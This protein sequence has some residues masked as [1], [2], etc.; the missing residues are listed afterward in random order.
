[1]LPALMSINRKEFAELCVAKLENMI[2]LAMFRQV[3]K[4][5]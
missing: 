1:M 4:L 2:K 3:L 5:G